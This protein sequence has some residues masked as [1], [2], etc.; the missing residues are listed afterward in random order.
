[1]TQADV[2]QDLVVCRLIVHQLARI[3]IT[4]MK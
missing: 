1:M 3:R 2:K 4:Y